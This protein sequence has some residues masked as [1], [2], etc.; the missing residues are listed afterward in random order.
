VGDAPTVIAIIV[1]GVL[2]GVGTWWTRRQL[3]NAGIGVASETIVKNLRELSDTWEEKYVMERESRVNAE[4]ALAAIKTEQALE[5]SRA[6][7]C[8][9]DL[10]D[11]RS[12]IRLLER[13]RTPRQPRS[14]A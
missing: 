11:A 13:R 4:T 14:G 7:E 9:A 1:A 5:R 3:R 10:D 2:G 6:A 8:R 12:Q